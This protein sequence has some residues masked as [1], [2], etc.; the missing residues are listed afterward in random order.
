MAE[1]RKNYE[2]CS[3]ETK[4]WNKT[5]WHNPQDAQ[6]D[7]RLKEAIAKRHLPVWNLFFV[8]QE[9]IDMFAVRPKE[10][11]AIPYSNN[12]GIEFIST[13]AKEETGKADEIEKVLPKP[14][15]DGDPR[16]FHSAAVTPI[17][18][19]EAWIRSLARTPNSKALTLQNDQG[20]SDCV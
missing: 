4:N 9:L 19:V 18:R 2:V 11:L 14:A 20:S 10:V 1:K 15:Q 3:E 12:H 6:T 17:L 13:E 16:G 7:D 5:E 8:C